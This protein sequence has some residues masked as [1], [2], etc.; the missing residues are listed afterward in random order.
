MITSL[1]PDKPNVLIRTAGQEDAMRPW[2]VKPWMDK[3]LTQDTGMVR[4]TVDFIGHLANSL[5]DP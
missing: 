3:I 5:V 2:M 1:L 4:T